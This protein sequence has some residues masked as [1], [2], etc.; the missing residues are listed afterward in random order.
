MAW[1]M[2]GEVT[3]CEHREYGFAQIQMT[4]IDGVNA[5]VDALFEGLGDEMQV[6][7]SVRP[8]YLDLTTVPQGVDVPW[9]STLG[10]SCRLPRNWENEDSAIRSTRPQLKALLRYPVSS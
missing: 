6:R 7:S 5:S 1:H 4:K 8:V 9:R 10:A 2:K 3:K